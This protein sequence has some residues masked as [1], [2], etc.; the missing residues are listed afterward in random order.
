MQGAAWSA[1]EKVAVVHDA[2]PA[3]VTGRVGGPDIPGLAQLAGEHW[4]GDVAVYSHRQGEQRHRQDND[5]EQG[6]MSL[7]LF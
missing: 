3:P 1:A 6:A 4:T 2:A 7:R 5:A